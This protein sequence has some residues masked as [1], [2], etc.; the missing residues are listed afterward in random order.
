MLVSVGVTAAV[1]T[2][3]EVELLI[4]NVVPSAAAL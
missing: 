3:T 2:S 1:V 4:L